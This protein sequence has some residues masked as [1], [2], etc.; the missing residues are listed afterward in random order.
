[1]SLGRIA[2][3]QAGEADIAA[4]LALRILLWPDAVALEHRAEIEDLVGNP[5]EGVGF[6]AYEEMHQPI[7]F[8]EAT[9]RH[10]YVNGCTTTP[11][12]FLEGLYVIEPARRSGV[13]AGLI[14]AVEAWALGLGCV[15]F[16]SDALVE[17]ATSHAV[18]EAAGFVETE[19]VVYFRKL[20]REPERGH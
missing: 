13:A 6:L 12:A 15:E 7:G 3:M 8:A 9:L 19:R 5:G 2:I 20:L 4:W 16:A 14:G 10:D 17:N 18:H 11:V 1:M